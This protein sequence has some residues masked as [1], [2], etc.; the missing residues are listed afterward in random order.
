MEEMYAMSI[1]IHNGGVLLLIGIIVINWVHLLRASNIRN[2]ARQMRIMM[3]ISS[4]LIFLILFTGAVMMA[5]KHLSFTLENVVMILF[6]VL[7]IVLE[8]KRYGSLKHINLKAQNAFVD[9][10]RRAYRIFGVELAM[11][12]VMS[13]WMLA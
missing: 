7:L 4:S 1:G 13:V 3:P 2:Y 5:A 12:V 11:N 10:K 8:A 6:A 9:Y